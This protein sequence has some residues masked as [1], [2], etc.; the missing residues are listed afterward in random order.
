MRVFIAVLVLIFSLQSWTKADNIREFEI[1]GISIDDS[2]LDYFSTKEIKEMKI[3][4]YPGSDKYIMLNY[5]SPTKLGVY[6]SMSFHVRKNDKSFIIHSLK[7]G[8]YYE[9]NFNECMDKKK[10]LVEDLKLIFNKTKFEEYDFKYKVDDGK[11]IAYINAF[12][13]KNNDKIRAW[14]V[15]WSKV[16]EKKRNFVDNLALSISPGYFLDWLDNDA[17]Q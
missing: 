12:A 14:C 13:F 8:I 6:D 16:T 10:K 17:K 3:T 7:A 9:S 2:L 5:Y 11:S 15:N 4:E 1:E